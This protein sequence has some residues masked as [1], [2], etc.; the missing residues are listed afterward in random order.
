MGDNVNYA[1]YEYHVD[2]NKTTAAVRLQLE[3]ALCEVTDEVLGGVCSLKELVYRPFSDPFLRERLRREEFGAELT[4]RLAQ[5]LRGLLETVKA[6]IE[7]TK[8]EVR[9]E[10]QEFARKFDDAYCRAQGITGNEDPRRNYTQQRLER[11]V[12]AFSVEKDTH[13][14]RTSR[15]KRTAYY[16]SLFAMFRDELDQDSDAQS[17]EHSV[18]DP[19]SDAPQ[20]LEQAHQV[21]YQA[22]RVKLHH[23]VEIIETIEEN[24]VPEPEP[25]QSNNNTKPIFEDKPQENIDDDENND[26]EPELTE[27]EVDRQ[28]VSSAA[29]GDK[30]LKIKNSWVVV[31]GQG[32]ILH[33]GE[34][35][36]T[37]TVKY[38]LENDKIIDTHEHGMINI[39]Q[40][41]E[42]RT[43]VICFIW[44]QNIIVLK[45]KQQ[46]RCLPHKLHTPGSKACNSRRQ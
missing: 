35:N 36:S 45:D 16:N 29:F 42:H 19:S 13:R 20:P 17:P 21:T 4:G 37:Q 38:D 22:R 3:P 15:D 7:E 30:L 1:D 6:S 34:D 25:P 44:K 46:F 14:T 31:N 24:Q 9:Q 8:A 18:S 26:N 2:L 39:L 33:V 11:A 5:R 32:K 43:L 27:A 40:Y 23:P 28:R 10:L 12:L 41:V